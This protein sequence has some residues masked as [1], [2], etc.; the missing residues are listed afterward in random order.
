MITEYKHT[1]C[2]TAAQC[3]AQREVAPATLIQ[4]II[5]VATEHA[6]TINIGFQRMGKNSALWVLSRVAYEIKRYPGILEEYTIS[7]ISSGFTS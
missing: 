6:D 1:Y 2:L 4:Q 3:N 5:D 7:H